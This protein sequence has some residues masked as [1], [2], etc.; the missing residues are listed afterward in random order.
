MEVENSADGV[1]AGDSFFAGF[2]L[3]QNFFLTN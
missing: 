3:P 2:E 1:F